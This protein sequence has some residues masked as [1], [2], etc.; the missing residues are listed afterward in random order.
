MLC[1]DGLNV[2]ML[3]D[4][5]ELFAWYSDFELE[6]EGFRVIPLPFD[7][8]VPSLPEII[9]ED[10]YCEFMRASVATTGG[11]LVLS[12]LRIISL[13]TCRGY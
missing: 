6:Y 12:V 11:V 3:P 8:T 9:S 13:K 2:G 7:G 10:G 5:I 4:G 1:K